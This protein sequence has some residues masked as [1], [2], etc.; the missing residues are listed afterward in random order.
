MVTGEQYIV[1]QMISSSLL[2]CEKLNVTNLSLTS[3]LVGHQAC[4]EIVSRQPLKVWSNV[5]YRGKIFACLSKEVW[6]VLK[7]I[8]FSLLYVDM[9]GVVKIDC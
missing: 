2:L 5:G 9:L 4:T 8:T 3:P 7:H 1:F 6:C